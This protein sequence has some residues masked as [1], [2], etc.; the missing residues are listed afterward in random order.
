MKPNPYQ[1]IDGTTPYQNRGRFEYFSGSLKT[2]I[3][4]SRSGEA[5]SPFSKVVIG[6]DREYT[7]SNNTLKLID[8]D[9][10]TTSGIISLKMADGFQ[11]LFLM[12]TE[13]NDFFEDYNLEGISSDWTN[14]DN[15]VEELEGEWPT[16]WVQ[17]DAEFSDS[18]TIF[19]LDS[20][21]YVSVD[22]DAESSEAAQM[23]VR[24][25]GVDY[26][27]NRKHD[28][29]VYLTMLWIRKWNPDFIR[30]MPEDDQEEDY[31]P[32]TPTPTVCPV[33]Q[34]PNEYGICVPIEE[35]EEGEEGQKEEETVEEDVSAFAMVAL[36]AAVGGII[37]LALRRV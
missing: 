37:Y 2:A 13:N 20:G 19:G 32:P 11:G 30:P 35:E 18:R 17:D 31:V 3:E 7:N 36:L 16:V 10:F 14:V 22:I 6:G 23:R 25:G 1:F 26:F 12:R 21:D 34:A 9:G 29:E 5:G 4:T 8:S 28:N 33:G 15:H 24:I 27:D